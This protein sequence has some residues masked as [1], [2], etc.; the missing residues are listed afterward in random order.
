MNKVNVTMQVELIQ[1][2]SATDKI[3]HLAFDRLLK[4]FVPLS[5]F[6]TLRRYYLKI[7]IFGT[8]CICEHFSCLSI[9]KDR[10]HIRIVDNQEIHTFTHLLSST[11]SKSL[12]KM[13]SH[14]AC[15]LFRFLMMYDR[16]TCYVAPNTASPILF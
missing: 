8:C 10:N 5:G 1:L 11:R 16:P 2:Q 7:S 4:H 3:Q 12:I 6:P 15:V 9:A 13:V 14:M